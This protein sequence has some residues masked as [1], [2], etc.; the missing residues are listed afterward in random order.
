MCYIDEIRDEGTLTTPVFD[1]RS[2]MNRIGVKSGTNLH[3]SRPQAG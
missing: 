2:D 3:S 1:S